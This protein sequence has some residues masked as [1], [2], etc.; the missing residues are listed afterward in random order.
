[1]NAP[2]RRG[3]CPGLSVPMPTGD[4][5][6]VRLLPIGTIPLG[7][8]K[9][10]CAA[11]RTF[12]NGIVEITARGSIQ[13][14]GLD[15]ASA[16]R[17]AAAVGVLGIAA[18]DGVPIH[19]SPLTGLDPDEIL[20]SG[21]IAA[22]LRRA[23][24][25]NKLAARLSPKVSVI[26]DGS[27]ALDL[28]R[29]AADI[30]LRAETNDGA[31]LL[32]ISVGGE[33]VS[34]TDLGFVSPGYGVA[35]VIALLQIIAQHGRDA[36]AK[37]ILAGQEI[38]PFGLAIHDL[39][40]IPA[41]PRESG[42]PELDSRLR[43]NER[44]TAIGAHC[45]RDGS[46]AF[47]LGLAFGHANAASL[48][49]L[50]QTAEAMGAIGMRP[51]PER[52][53]MIVGLAQDAPGAFVAEAERLGF[54]VRSDD[55]RRHVFACAGAPI[56]ASAHMAARAAA[57]RVAADNA[58]YLRGSFTIHLSGCAKGCAHPVPATRTIVGTAAGC[59]LIANGTAR[60]RPFANVRKD[61]VA[62]AIARHVR[63]LT[64]ETAHG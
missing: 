57:P 39:H 15:A 62:A 32:R 27:G 45:L 46:F 28:D 25:D 38:Q 17:F 31:A 10:L 26:I 1:M 29:L 23:L 22:D 14:R 16:P 61:D 4:G 34:A 7:A 13:V 58:G 36:R 40:V 51:A 12:G 24:A 49:S 44:K 9:E 55:P 60:D 52:S 48:E 56:C 35:A 59:A 42:D 47:G 2:L 41:R 63:K 5:L 19:S 18:Q 33:A 11:A 20:N 6:L 50:T 3:A 43:G 64:G 21:A 30:R 54:I 8:F 37:D 53:L